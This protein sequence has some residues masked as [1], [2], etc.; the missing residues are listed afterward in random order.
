M[1]LMIHSLGEIPAD[2]Q[3]GYY[4][5]LLDYGWDE[6]LAKCCSETSTEWPTKRRATMP[7]CCEVSSGRTSPMRFCLGITSMGNL[8]IRSCPPF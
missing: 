6:P 2:V 3:R 4:V 5:Y 8:L 1:G 7:S